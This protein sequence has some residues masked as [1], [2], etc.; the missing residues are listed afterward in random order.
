M[1]GG[2][3]IFPNESVVL[4]IPT[5]IDLYN[6]NLVYKKASLDIILLGHISCSQISDPIN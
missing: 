4:H 2:V 3:Q 6:L 5:L 1:D